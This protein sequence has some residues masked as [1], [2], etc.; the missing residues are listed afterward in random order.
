VFVVDIGLEVPSDVTFN[1]ANADYMI[2]FNI[3]ILREQAL[4]SLFVIASKNVYD[5]VELLL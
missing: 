4:Y 5:C 2:I 1:H 3:N